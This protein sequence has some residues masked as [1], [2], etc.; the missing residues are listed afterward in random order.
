[1]AIGKWNV[2]WE[3]LSTTDDKEQGED[4][5]KTMKGYAL[6]QPN[7]KVTFEANGYKG[8]LL[9]ESRLTNSLI[10]EIDKNVMRLRNSENIEFIS[11]RIIEISNEHMRF[12]MTQDIVMNFTR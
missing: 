4:I 5:V 11:C 2:V 3:D 6:F 7:G 9:A 12:E 8:C 1:M 10:W